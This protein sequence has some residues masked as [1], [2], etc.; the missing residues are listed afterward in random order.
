MFRA[1]L[2]GAAAFL[3]FDLLESD[4]FLSG[5]LFCLISLGWGLVGRPVVKS[6]SLF[7]QGRLPPFFPAKICT[8][9]VCQVC[10][11][12]TLVVWDKLAAR[13]AD[14][15]EPRALQAQPSCFVLAGCVLTHRGRYCCLF[16]VSV[17]VEVG[18][19][20]IPCWI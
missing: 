2:Q 18:I 12:M 11:R 3:F 20:A 8:F 10:Q 14:C 7:G 13:N 19:T 15:L 16:Q 4:E 6:A 17:E 5:K 9:R 1:Q